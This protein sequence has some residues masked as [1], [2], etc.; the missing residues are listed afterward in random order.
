MVSSSP[1]PATGSNGAPGGQSAGNAPVSVVLVHGAFADGSSWRK[2]IPLLQAAGLQVAAVQNPLTSLSDDVEFTRRIIDAQPGPVVL[3]GHSWGG[4]VIT[5]AG[6]HP[7]V[8]ALVYVAAF[9]PAKGESSIDLPKTF[10]AMPGKEG[11][12]VTPDGF[13]LLT[14][15]SVRDN[16]AQDVDADEANLIAVTQGAV[17]AAAF[18]ETLTAAAWETR[19]CWYV[20]SAADRM[21]NPDAQRALAARI[22]A[23]VVTLQTS[24]VPMLSQPDAVAGHI[25]AAAESLR[26]EQR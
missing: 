7:K 24:H 14:A 8:K 21:I 19:P 6:D 4:S 3:V 9:A 12:I 2:V 22:G 26:V 15:E 11:R 17:R 25:L 10:P 5:Q 18:E 20:I 23:T 16:F 13:H 1:N